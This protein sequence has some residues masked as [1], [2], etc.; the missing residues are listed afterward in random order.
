MGQRRSGTVFDEYFIVMLGQVADQA[1]KGV[2]DFVAAETSNQS[3]RLERR[4]WM[5]RATEGG[6]LAMGCWTWA[7][8]ASISPHYGE[9][10]SH[11]QITRRDGGLHGAGKNQRFSLARRPLAPLQPPVVQP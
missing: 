2:N 10:D 7:T 4:R 5:T 8:L 11:E 6:S 3:N 9:E 1:L